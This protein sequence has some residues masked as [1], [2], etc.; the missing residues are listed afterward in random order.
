M[1]LSLRRSRKWL[2]LPAAMLIATV[3]WAPDVQA[4]NVQQLTEQRTKQDVLN[5]WE[6][7]KPMET[8]TTYMPADQIYSESPSVTA[9]F[10][11]GRIKSEYVEDGIRAVNFVRYLAGLPDDVTA[12]YSL[13]EQQ[14]AAAM[15]IAANKQLTHY[16]S[17]PAGIDEALYASGK[18]GARTSNL[19]SGGP[20]FYNNVLGYMADRDASNTDRVGHRRWII[21][22]EMKQTMF[23]MAHATNN[24]AYASMY[25][26]DKSRPKSEVQYDYIAWPSAGYFPEEVFRTIDPWSVSL[27]PEKYDRKKTD[28]I[29][30]KLTRVRDGKVWSFDENDKDKS[31]KYFN[32][33]TGAYGVSFAVVFRPDGIEDFAMDDAFDVE[34]TGL[35]TVG[36]SPTEVEFTTTFFK[37]MPT[38]LARYD[39]ELKKGETLQM[40]LH[41]GF[42]NSGNTFESGDDRIVK[43]DSTGKVTAVGKG[44]TWISANNYLG[45]RSIVYIQVED[46]PEEE[47]VSNWAQADYIQAKANGLIGWPFDRSYQRSINRMEFT[48]MAVHMIETALGRDLYTDVLGVKSPFN[49]IDDW[50]ITWANQNGIINGTSPNTF[51]PTAT[52]TREQAATLILKVYKKTNELKGTTGSAAGSTS[53]SLFADDTKISPWAKEEVYQAVNLSLM[54]GMAKNQFNPKGELTFEQTYVLLLNCF[55][56][57]MEK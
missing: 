6:Q 13:T 26:F 14:Q 23:G 12:N 19:Y 21:N 46:G 50:N 42:Q 45:M 3:L 35:Y 8:G 49:D 51:S 57:L 55:E 11:A 44:S 38:L 16:P 36:G 33:N 39:I 53:T 30:V 56:M 37:L 1:K 18:D 34:I 31:G 43:I 9:P 28:Q 41:E 27:N 29:Q 2:I 17:K 4:A 48:E 25:A 7:Y 20:T 22:P 5:K 10:K 32:V 52:I 15:V 47:K 40:G 54:N 24:V